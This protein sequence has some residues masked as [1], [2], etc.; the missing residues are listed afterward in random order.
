MT[1]KKQD[2]I[3]IIARRRKLAN[4]LVARGYSAVSQDDGLYEQLVDL[5]K[6]KYLDVEEPTAGHKRIVYGH[7][8]RGTVY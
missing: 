1:P 6:H 2:C 8:Y 5:V 4:D 7:A 3:A